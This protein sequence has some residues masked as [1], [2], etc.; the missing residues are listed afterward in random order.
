MNLPDR[1]S[2]P[3]ALTP[4]LSL[5]LRKLV[6][7]NLD[8]L[9][10]SNATAQAE[11]DPIMLFDRLC[12]PGSLSEATIQELVVAVDR[13]QVLLQQGI[14]GRQ[15]LHQ[16]EEGIFVLLGLR[17]TQSHAGGTILIVDDT[18]GNL[19]LL[20]S[21]LVQQGYAVRNAINGSLA[22]S[23]AKTIRPDLILL[24][25]MMPGMDG[26]EV[27]RR[28][29]QDPQTQDIPIIFISA[30]DGSVDK[31]K[32]FEVGGVDYVSKPFQIEEVLVRIEH[33]LR[34]SNLQSRLEEQNLRLQEDSQN[35]QSLELY[36][37]QLWEGS[38]DGMYRTL[39]DGTI[40]EVNQAFADL[41]GYDSPTQLIAQNIA[42]LYT[43]PACWH[44]FVAQMQQ[45]G[46]VNNLESEMRQLSNEV[47][48]ISTTAQSLTNEVGQVLSYEGR[49]Q[50]M[51]DRNAIA[52]RENSRRRLRRLLIS[53]FPKA[54]AKRFIHD[55][56]NRFAQN[57]AQV[58]LLLI[59]IDSADLLP[60]NYPDKIINT[61]NQVFNLVETI[62]AKHGIEHL[63]SMGTTILVAA[64]VP[65]PQDDHADR[66][67][68]FALDLQE[69]IRPLPMH[70][71]IHS[72]PIVAGIVGVEQRLTYE[73]YG[74]TLTYAHYLIHQSIQEKI[75]LS[76][77]T[78]AALSGSYNLKDNTSGTL[79][80]YW[81]DG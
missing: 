65:T 58:T 18:P 66:I 39:A 26:Y 24:D 44:E 25:I 47:I 55:P 57:F 23:G 81:L 40:T 17:L 7:Q 42:D 71:G 28:L 77:A 19:R 56:Q 30:I 12:Q 74:E 79:E 80:S 15:A 33:Q 67:L 62:A 49:I 27:C 70:M 50:E 6:R 22:L 78:H 10:L 34:I 13:H 63:R 31:V 3:Q 61:F 21:A 73:L 43:Q 52:Q 5:Y 41:L 69:Q 9:A 68:R 29:K 46:Q 48:W 51:Q 37:R 76:A 53:L 16:T 59:A 36:Y 75:L 14:K 8:R 11:L 38:S 54:V 45:K 60:Q 35:R 72:G 4:A 1:Q 64:G 2:A 32:A 20:S